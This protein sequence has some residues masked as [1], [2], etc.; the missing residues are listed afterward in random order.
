MHAPVNIAIPTA[1]SVVSIPTATTTTHMAHGIGV[2]HQV[3]HTVSRCPPRPA[4]GRAPPFPRELLRVRA[5][6]ARG[7]IGVPALEWV[8]GDGGDF[9]FGEVRGHEEGVAGRE[10]GQVVD[11]AVEF[12]WETMHGLVILCEKEGH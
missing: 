6:G 11:I 12:F 8:G 3:L 9:V 5:V 10:G 1:A 7:F 4:G 2:P